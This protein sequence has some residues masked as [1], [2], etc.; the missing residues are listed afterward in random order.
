VADLEIGSDL[1]IP[2]LEV[3]VRK[4]VTIKITVFCDIMSYSLVDTYQRFGGTDCD[5]L[6]SRT[7]TFLSRR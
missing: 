2:N 1:Y 7:I 3:K 6:L 4:A 5:L